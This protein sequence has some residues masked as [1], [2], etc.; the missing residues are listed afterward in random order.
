MCLIWKGVATAEKLMELFGENVVAWLAAAWILGHFSK[1][2]SDLTGLIR[3]RRLYKDST[4]KET[5]IGYRNGWQSMNGHD[6]RA[7]TCIRR[8]QIHSVFMHVRVLPFVIVHL[9]RLNANV[10]IETRRSGLICGSQL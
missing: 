6:R 5:R 10:A 3:R 8:L 4:P 9:S 1:I 2:T 7:Q